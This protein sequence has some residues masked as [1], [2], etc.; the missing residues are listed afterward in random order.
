LELNAQ[1]DAIERESSDQLS[2]DEVLVQDLCD[3][4]HGMTE[5]EVCFV[6]SVAEQVASGRALT[7]LQRCTAH[8][9]LDKRWP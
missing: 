2:R 1:L 4:D 5:W 3:I 6:E 9:I 8:E 7:G